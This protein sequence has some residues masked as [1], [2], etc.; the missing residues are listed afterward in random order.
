MLLLQDYFDDF[1]KGSSAADRG[2]VCQIKKKHVNY[3]QVNADISD[4]FAHLW[5]FMCLITDTFA[6]L[7]AMEIQGFTDHA[8]RPATAPDG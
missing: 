7:H 5:E 2:T 4:N 6:C 3:R 1:F 8:S